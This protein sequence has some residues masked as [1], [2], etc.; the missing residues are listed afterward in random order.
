MEPES[1]LPYSQQPT[2]GSYSEVKESIPHSHTL[3]LEESF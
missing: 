2:T 1:A 3:F